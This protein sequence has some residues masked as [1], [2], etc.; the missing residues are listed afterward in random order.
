MVEGFNDKLDVIGVVLMKLDG[1]IC[2]GV[3]LLIWVV[4]GKLIKF[5]G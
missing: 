5:V 1:D 3:V 4:I 2:G